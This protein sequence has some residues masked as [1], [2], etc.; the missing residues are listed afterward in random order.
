[1]RN[2]S[3]LFSLTVMLAILAFA[4]VMSPTTP[5]AAG[6][7]VQK[8]YSDVYWTW[9]MENAVGE[10]KLVRNNQG[11]HAK[12]ETPVLPARQAVT[13]WFIVF[14]Y[15]DLCSDGEC[16]LDDL[17]NTPARGDFHWADGEVIQAGKNT[18]FEGRL[19]VGDLSYSG[20]NEVACPETQDCGIPLENPEGALVILATHSH[21]PALS[22]E[23]LENQLS[24][25]SGGCDVFLGPDGFAAG[26]GD[27]PDEVGECSTIQ[28]SPHA[29]GG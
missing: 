2:K 3:S 14:N 17:G 16:G 28:L 10:S 4:I 13:L 6:S 11:I 22:G 18:K 20:L 29:P 23:A 12:F 25:F 9:D 21:G 26:P 1:M 5:A 24:T 19:R 7:S 15:P 8:S 27:L